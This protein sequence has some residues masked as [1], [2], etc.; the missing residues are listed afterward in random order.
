MISIA[1]CQSSACILP[2]RKIC[3]DP[4]GNTTL[5]AFNL[6]LNASQSY[7]GDNWVS[8]AFGAAS[9]RFR[10]TPTNYATTW[11]TCPVAQFIMNMNAANLVTF[12]NGETTVFEEGEIFFC[13]DAAGS[14][15]KSQN[16]HNQSRFSVFVEVDSSFNAGPCPGNYA[17]ANRNDNGN[18]DDD[19]PLCKDLS[20]AA[21]L[22]L[23][24]FAKPA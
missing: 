3:A 4:M 15:H 19:L 17:K 23:H 24:Q 16:Y 8:T 11:H 22:A 7:G 21:I 18:K 14:G 20:E 12:S 9:I 6:T 10:Y 2:V 13:D 1:T 5:G